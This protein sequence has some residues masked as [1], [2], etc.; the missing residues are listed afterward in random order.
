MQD[1]HEKFLACCKE[2]EKEQNLVENLQVFSELVILGDSHQDNDDIFPYNPPFDLR[3]MIERKMLQV[4][5]LI[6]QRSKSDRIVNTILESVQRILYS[7]FPHLAPTSSS[8]PSL[9]S[10]T[11]TSTSSSPSAITFKATKRSSSI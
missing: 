9:S 5:L 7:S 6:L 1:A 8:M 2:I 3:T 10:P 11:Q 4:L